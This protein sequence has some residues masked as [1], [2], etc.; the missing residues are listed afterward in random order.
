MGGP[1]NTAA[2]GSLAL[3]A[4][5]LAR[6]HRSGLWPLVRGTRTALEPLDL[7]I[8]RGQQVALL[9]PNGSGKSTLLRLCAGVDRQSAGELEVLG[10]STAESSVRRRVG[11]LPDEGGLPGDLPARTL[12]ALTAAFHGLNRREA[13]RRVEAW[14]ERVGLSASARVPVGR[15][16]RGMQRRFGLAHALIT[17]PELVLLDE[18]TAGLDAPGFEVFAEL[19]SEARERGATLLFATHAI[20]DVLEHCERVVVLM[21]GRL[22]ADSPPDALFRQGGERATL[23]G[24]YR[25]LRP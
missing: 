8:R 22:V 16:S 3:E 23:R 21:D 5:A 11:Y 15:F 10:G 24:L 12:L 9:G 1:D 13:A 7:S 4:R 20:D 6:H 17:E 14:L 19:V 2:A 18:P 25:S